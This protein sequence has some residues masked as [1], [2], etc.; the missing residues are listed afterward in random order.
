[1]PCPRL[2]WAWHHGSRWRQS[3][4]PSRMSNH[5]SPVPGGRCAPPRAPGCATWPASPPELRPRVRPG[6][7][8]CA[9]HSGRRGSRRRRRGRP[10]GRHREPGRDRLL[11]GRRPV[12]LPPAA[13]TRRPE[14][15]GGQRLR[16]PVRWKPGH[17]PHPGCRRS[18]P[19]SHVHRR[20]PQRQRGHRPRAL[21]ARGPYDQ[22]RR[23]HLRRRPWLSGSR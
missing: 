17:G 4:A 22:R 1:M 11:R 13:V 16:Q 9:V 6:S 19:G 21:V 2:S 15:D 23:R 12:R 10:G 8:G 7:R 3:V 18:V 20:H 14:R 5:T